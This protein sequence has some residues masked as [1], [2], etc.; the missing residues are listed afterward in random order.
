MTAYHFPSPTK[1]LIPISDIQERKAAR[2][3]IIEGVEARRK[4]VYTRF[5]EKKRQLQPDT[6]LL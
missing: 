3:K 4:T 2:R 5:M 6:K 1:I